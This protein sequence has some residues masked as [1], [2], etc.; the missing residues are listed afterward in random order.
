MTD[1][2]KKTAGIAI[3]SMVFG[4]LGFVCL[5]PL[6]AIPAVIC[7]HIAK[8]R[9]KASAGSLNGDGFARAGLIL[10]YVGIGLMIVSIF[11]M[12]LIT[13][14]NFAKAR[15][16]AR[17]NACINNMK[18][19]DAA[20]EQ[21]ELKYNYRE[22]TTVPDNQISEYLKNGL[23]GLKCPKGGSYSI[24]P[25]GKAPSCSEHGESPAAMK[26]R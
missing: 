6:G 3:T 10:G 15:E 13:T 4:I 9:I 14:P 24:N 19:I 12:F 17:Q 25:T 5:G 8:S 23:S 2:Q 7:G 21:T 18:Q 22:G 11:I 16:T 20:K 26:I 1:I